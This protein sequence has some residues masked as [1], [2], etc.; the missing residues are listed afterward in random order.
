MSIPKYSTEPRKNDPKS[1]GDD[2][3]RLRSYAPVVNP[4]ID[5]ELRDLRRYV[6]ALEERLGTLIRTE[7]ERIDETLTY[8]ALRIDEV[9]L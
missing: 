1:A 7:V 5:R 2:L 6:D 9:E 4:A 8:H 3:V